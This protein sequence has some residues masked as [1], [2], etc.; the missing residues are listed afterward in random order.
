MTRS[1]SKGKGK[2]GK[3]KNST[4]CGCFGRKKTSGEDSSLL[5]ARVVPN[6]PVAPLQKILPT[7][8][9][10]QRQQKGQLQNQQQQQQ[11]QQPQPQQQQQFAADHHAEE[12]QPLLECLDSQQRLLLD[13]ECG[14]VR[15][16]TQ[17]PPPSSVDSEDSDRHP[18]R[19]HPLP[20]TTPSRAPLLSVSADSLE[21]RDS[22]CLS[23][24]PPLIGLTMFL[25][26]VAYRATTPVREQYVYGYFAAAHSPFTDDFVMGNRDRSLTC[27]VSLVDSLYSQCKYNGMQYLM[28]F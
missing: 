5:N 28:H 12:K 18:P 1:G 14:D 15:G 2:T 19:K 26:A 6:T 4:K 16:A 22:G 10:P 8:V 7:Q 11:Q 21:L 13:A 24:R 17:P 9:Q 27:K 23:S 20:V 3:Q 25:Y